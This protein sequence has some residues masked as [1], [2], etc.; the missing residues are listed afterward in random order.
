MK[1]EEI[2]TFD[3]FLFGEMIHHKLEMEIPVF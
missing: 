2:E 1:K 3:E